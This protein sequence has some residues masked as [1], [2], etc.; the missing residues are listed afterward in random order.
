MDDGPHTPHVQTASEVRAL[1]AGAG[2][3]PRHRL[4]QNFL[5]DGNLMRLLVREA[6]I[7]PDHTV[8]EVGCGTGSLTGLLAMAAKRVV[9][10]ECDANLMP[11]AQRQVPAGN[12]T[13]IACDALEGPNKLSGAIERALSASDPAP[14]VLA[15]NLPYQIASPLIVLLLSR[16]PAPTA[17]TCMVQAEVADRILAAPGTKAYGPLSVMVQALCDAG[18]VRQV[19]ASAFW[20][21][22]EVASA[23]IRLVPR[24]DRVGDAARVEALRWVTRRLFA[25]RRKTLRSVLKHSDLGE[26]AV[27]AVQD[28]L[29][30]A[31]ASLGARAEE[32]TIG[33][34]LAAADCLRRGGLP[35]LPGEPFS[36]R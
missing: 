12:V 15:A 5:I 35:D 7:G 18:R 28:A 10:V 13:W 6:R 23:I 32:L 25:A 24:A 21:R 14:W 31:G 26:E 8:L 11:I 3:R 20:P 19:P 16:R 9:A 22:P 1:L 27:R 30:V 36:F 4:G 33:Q 34:F 29:A 17:M 2:L